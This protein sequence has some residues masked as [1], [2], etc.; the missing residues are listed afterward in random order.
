MFATIISYTISHSTPTHTT[1]LTLTLTL[2]PSHPY[3]SPSL[4]THTHHHH[5]TP[6]LITITAHHHHC[7]SSPSL[8]IITITAHHH[9]HCTPT[10]TAHPHTSPSL[11]T[12]HHHC[13]PTLITITAHPNSSLS[14]HTH[15]LHTSHTSRRSDDPLVRDCVKSFIQDWTIVKRK[16]V[17]SVLSI[18]PPSLPYRFPHRF[19]SFHGHSEEFLTQHFSTCKRTSSYSKLLPR[20]HYEI[21]TPPQENL[22]TVSLLPSF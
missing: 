9:H 7:T 10:I 19:G 12:H 20:H 21:D 18:G 3:T 15:I 6:I 17:G 16:Y 11:H 2:T 13:T 4:H 8:H 1:Q 5:C 22:D 14:L